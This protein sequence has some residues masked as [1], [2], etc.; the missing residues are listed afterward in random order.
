MI[1][2]YQGST[3]S[4]TSHPSRHPGTTL[5]IQGDRGMGL[6]QWLEEYLSNWVL[7]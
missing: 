2:A 5:L 1:L 7:E 4:R 6:P 3:S